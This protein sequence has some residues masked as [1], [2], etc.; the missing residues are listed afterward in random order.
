MTTTTTNPISSYTSLCLKL[1]G[2]IL[3][4]SSLI[5]YLTLAIPF[6]ALDPQWQINF[7]TQLV[8]RGIVP[9]VGIVFL[10]I[11]YWMDEIRVGA[12][13]ARKSFDLRV[14]VFII[15]SILGL[16]FLLLV[17]LHLN[18]LRV[19]SSSVLEQIEQGAGEAETRIQTQFDQLN[20]LT[21]DPQRLQQLNQQVAQI[22][23]AL[24]SGQFQGQT[25]EPQQREQLQQTRTQLQNLRDLAQNPDALQARLNELQVQLR[26]QKL[27]REQQAKTEA[28]KQG[29]RIGLSS[30]ML[31]IGYIAVGWLGLKG[32]SRA[33]PARR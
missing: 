8:D 23:Q 4:L 14:P 16:L 5:D 28:L 26:D 32:I 27:Q 6:N 24:S 30:L 11:G 2:V 21:Q 10:L 7:T 22:D 29:L 1:V 19:A 9:L 20:T 33:K 25:L 13:A 3:I 12:E 18:N 15:A 17:P 31:A